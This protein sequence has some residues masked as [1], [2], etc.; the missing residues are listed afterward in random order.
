MLQ[1]A[2]TQ[3]PELRD[4][5]LPAPPSWWPP[6]PG[7]WLLA[8]AIAALSFFIF[9]YL[10]KKAQRARRRRALLEEF[11]RAIAAARNDAPALAAALSAFLRRQDLRAAAGLRDEAWLQHLDARI[12]S[13]EYSRGVGR[14]LIEAPFRAQAE[15]DA[16]AL[17]ALV[18]RTVRASFDREAARA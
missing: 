1:S 2:A 8:C 18:R 7:W 12:A 16:A 3:G 14:A 4:I 9:L 13:D 10:Y 17:V 15:Y 11:D 5:H 6:A